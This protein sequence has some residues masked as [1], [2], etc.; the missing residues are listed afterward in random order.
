M[1]EY[2]KF[3]NKKKKF[4]SLVIGVLLSILAIFLIFT[5]NYNRIYKLLLDKD[6]EQIEFTSGFVTKLIQTEIE[7]LLSELEASQKTFLD[8]DGDQ[9]DEIVEHLKEI[10]K[11]RQFEKIGVVN[12][13]GTS[14]DDTGKV[15]K[16]EDTEFL[17][18]MKKN[19]RYVSNVMDVSDTMMIAVPI[20][21]N[22]QVTGAIWGYYSISEISEKIELTKGSQRYFQIIDDTG[23]YIS[24]S[25]NVYSFAKD[26]NIW[27]E[28]KRYEISDGITMEEIR[29]NVESGKSGQF[30]FAFEG[31]GRYVTYEPLGIKNWYVFSVLVEDYLGNYV[32]KIEQ[33]FSYLLWGVLG[34]IMIGIGLIGRSIY[35]TTGYIKE[36][37]EKLFT[38]NSLLFMVLKHTNDV[39]F[40]LNFVEQTLTIY[41]NKD[42]ERKICKNLDYFTPQN[43]LLNEKIC[44]EEYEKYQ[45]VYENLINGKSVESVVLKLK[46]DGK[47][48]YNK[49]H[50]KTIDKNHIVGFLEDYNEQEYQNQKMEEMSIKNQVDF[51]TKLYNREF[52]SQEVERILKDMANHKTEKKSALF[53]LDLDF[54]KKANDTLG[55]ITGDEILRESGMIMKSIIRS[56]DLAGRLGG[57]EFVLF[58]K[59]AKDVPA[60]EV[61][62]EKVNRALHKIYGEG[63]KTVTVSASIGIAVVTKEKTFAELYKMAD[64]ALYEAKK[65]GRNRY[66]IM[67]K[68]R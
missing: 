14:L 34:V 47:W 25:N 22:G 1:N 6:M 40:E 46:I 13:E 21:R 58:I 32:K 33:A 38:R 53:L 44:A 41:T 43:M 31:Q 19:K 62:A 35:V 68:E 30:H 2:T 67:S 54:L 3:E 37:N 55:H 36:Q 56:T 52:F 24:S 10:K 64:L 57:D 17:D 65:Q 45:M 59:D 11:E 20:T 60:L 8:H 39:P 16:S 29:S 42:E 49:I 28:L 61:C 50:I 63:E 18:S 15:E 7:N 12:L 9:Q 4:K 27:D 48:D 5:L 51:L 66:Y 23:L 26:M